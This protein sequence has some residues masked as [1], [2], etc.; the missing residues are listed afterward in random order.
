[1]NQIL[2]ST[3]KKAFNSKSIRKIPLYIY[4]KKHSDSYGAKNR[5]NLALLANRQL[6]QC[7]LIFHDLQSSPEG[8]QKCIIQITPYYS[9]FVKKIFKLFFWPIL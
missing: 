3:V 9:A 4:I 7:I 2:K 5:K 6:T 1:M 8:K